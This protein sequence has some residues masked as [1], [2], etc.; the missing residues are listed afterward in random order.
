MEDYYRERAA[1]YDDFYAVPERQANL[2]RLK[3]WVVDRTRRRNILEVAAG[4]CYW[5]EAA[6]TVAESI[7]ATD[8]N[9]ETLDVARDKRKLGPRVKLIVADAYALPQL[10]IPFDC[11]MAHMWWSHVPKQRRQEFLSHFVSRLQAGARVLMIDQF[12][13]P[14]RSSPASRE[15]EFGNLLT[16]RTLK[17]GATYEIIKNYP[18]PHELKTSFAPFCDDVQVTELEHFWALDAVL[19]TA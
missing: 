11:G 17:N 14:G 1:E 13:V 9:P 10:G 3:L 8:Y 18:S 19:R 2:E 15:D 5:T 12:F 6:A 4:T 7:V 16:R